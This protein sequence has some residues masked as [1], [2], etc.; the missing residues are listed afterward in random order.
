MK[1]IVKENDKLLNYLLNNLTDL[2][3]KKIKS[4]L[5]NEMINIKGRIITKYDYQLQKG[6]II[7]IKN[8]ILN[9]KDKINIHILYED[10][11]IIVV[12]KP[13]GLLTIGTDKHEKNTLY[14][15]VSEYVK[16][17]NPKNKIFIVHRLDRE[18]SGIVLFAKKES[19]K[20]AYQEKWNELV[21]IR[22]YIAIV[23]G[24]LD[25]KQGVIHTWLTENKNKV[26][27]ST[28]NKDIGKEAITEYK[29]QKENNNLSLLEI[30][31]KTGR[32]N[33]IR[34]HLKELE[35][36]ILGDIKY[37]GAKSNR[38]Y[39]HND[40]LVLKNPFNN[41]IL[42]FDLPLPNEFNKLMK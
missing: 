26:V 38:L 13:Y 29:V 16:R 24:Y 17:D 23:N 5:T 21:K 2:S 8:N 37:N 7:E 14:N 1:I 27:Y 30:Y 20:N 36:P 41:K 18:T 19:V 28:K 34:V 22:R 9:K 4:F 15:K 10:D 11:D 3:H 6:D 33:Q 32:K 40:K 35:H 42:S 25:K 12:N 31:I 39:L